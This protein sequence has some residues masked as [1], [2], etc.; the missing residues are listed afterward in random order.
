MNP[1]PRIE[2]ILVPHDFDQAAESALSYALGLAET[3][4]ARVTILHAYEMPVYGYPDAIVAS[5]ESATE[6]KRQCGEVLQRVASRARRSSVSVDT[7]LQ[8][9]TPWAEIVDTAER[10]HVDLI[11]MGTHGRR[12]I[13]RVLLGSVAEKVVRCAPCAVLTLHAAEAR[14]GLAVGA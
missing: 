7:A 13:H 11:V 14:E 10:L 4:G 8:Q 6:R 9:G 12:G 5:F 3:L 1:A 2:H